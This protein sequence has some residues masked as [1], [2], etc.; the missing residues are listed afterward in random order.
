MEW[1]L[2]LDDFKC[3]GINAVPRGFDEL[4]WL[5]IYLFEFPEQSTYMKIYLAASLSV[6]LEACYT[7]SYRRVRTK[8]YNTSG[9]NYV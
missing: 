4:L 7:S 5:L 9:G 3:S 8:K 1:E 2:E 6:S